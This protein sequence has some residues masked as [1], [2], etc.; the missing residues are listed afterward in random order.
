MS[1]ADFDFINNQEKTI[2]DSQKMLCIED[3]LFIIS[4]SLLFRGKYNASTLSMDFNSKK[5][6]FLE[7]LS[8]VTITKWRHFLVCFCVGDQHFYFFDLRDNFKLSKVCGN[9]N[10]GKYFSMINCFT[11][12]NFMM[13][14]I[15]TLQISKNLLL[16]STEKGRLYLLDLNRRITQYVGFIENEGVDVVKQILYLENGICFGF[17]EN[18]F[19]FIR[20]VFENKDKFQN[21]KIVKCESVEKLK[22]KTKLEQNKCKLLGN[23]KISD[24]TSILN[25]SLDWNKEIIELENIFL[26]FIPFGKVKR[27][28]LKTNLKNKNIIK[29]ENW[30]YANFRYSI[31]KYMKSIFVL[32]LGTSKIQ[33]LIP[34]K[35]IKKV[36]FSLSV[37]IL[38]GVI[39][40]YQD[41]L[42]LICLPE[43]KQNENN[44]EKLHYELRIID[45]WNLLTSEIVKLIQEK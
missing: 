37:T 22:C 32:F 2:H 14:V 41:Q 23:N 8:P 4:E 24:F 35:N 42:I 12:D 11:I 16:F 19:Y 21:Q 29:K 39:N 33:I 3:D 13:I 15:W 25:N 40:E 34:I 6:C 9:I 36:K 27:L 28:P 18:Y 5:F 31:Q 17:S 44:F 1:Q 26:H 10:Y 20:V 7:H 45:L 38:D 43:P 30:K